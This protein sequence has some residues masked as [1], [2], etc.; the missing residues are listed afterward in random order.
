VNSFW[1]FFLFPL[2]QAYHLPHHMFPEVPHYRLRRLHALLMSERPYRDNVPL[3][4]QVLGNQPGSVANSLSTPQSDAPA[5]PFIDV[6]VLDK[7][8]LLDEDSA[9]PAQ[10]ESRT[11]APLSTPR[12]LKATLRSAQA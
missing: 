9:P 7:E 4:T 10:P 8:T 11:A 5:E 1:R 2:G 6:S 3:V 12:E